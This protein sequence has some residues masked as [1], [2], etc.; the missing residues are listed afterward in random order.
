MDSL[1]APASLPS[2]KGDLVFPDSVS[3]YTVVLSLLEESK[4]IALT[5]SFNLTFF[6]LLQPDY[7]QSIDRWVASSVRPAGV[8]AFPRT[9]EDVSIL[10][11]W[12]VKEKVELVVW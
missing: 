4:V 11:K 1:R 10:I 5:S 12:A 7:R 6:L 3:S 8:V 9:D 2:F